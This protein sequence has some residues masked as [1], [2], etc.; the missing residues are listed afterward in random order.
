MAGA[1]T[2]SGDQG[3]AFHLLHFFLLSSRDANF[4]F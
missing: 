3:A 2:P 1:D 4:N